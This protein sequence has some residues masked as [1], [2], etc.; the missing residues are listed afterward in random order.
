MQ[1]ISQTSAVN[2]LEI[3]YNDRNHS[4]SMR[5][6]CIGSRSIFGKHTVNFNIEIKC[7]GYSMYKN[8]DNTGKTLAR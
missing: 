6:H 2:Q 3:N 5:Y 1:D 7:T 4:E 8:I